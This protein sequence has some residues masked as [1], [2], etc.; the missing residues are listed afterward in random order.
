[1]ASSS[2]VRSGIRRTPLT[3]A[4]PAYGAADQAC[5]ELPEGTEMSVRPLTASLFIVLSL[6]TVAWAEDPVRT[7]LASSV[8]RAAAQTQP[9]Q[10]APA[11][12]QDA[13]ASSQAADQGWEVEI[14]PI[15]IWAPLYIGKVTAPEFPDLPAPPGGGDRPSGETDTSLNGAAMAALRVEK[16]R[17]MARANLV[18]AGLSG[19]KERPYLKVSGDVIY[20]ELFT[21]IE[22]VDH[23]Y[24]E[25]GVRRLAVDVTAQV[26]DYP[27]VSRKPGV[28]D[29]IV[30]LTYR[31]PL[32]EHWLLTLHGD[33]GGFGVGSQVD[34][35]AFVTLDWRM[36]R[37]FGLTL[38]YALAYFRLEDTV[39]DS[40]RLERTLEL[41]ATFHGPII[42][43]KLLF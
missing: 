22:V 13:V 10:A 18:W 15:Y 28:W 3:A 43:F 12:K 33:G 41:G 35:N 21:G 26:L 29:P 42:G 36:V 27:E 2:M 4:E 37:H 5:A 8:A 38:G 17:W 31:A 23:L 1:M 40:T 14:A 30:G 6:A 11:V 32:S 7:P 25:G 20:G 19:E 34:A 24:V 16:G 9:A 39:L